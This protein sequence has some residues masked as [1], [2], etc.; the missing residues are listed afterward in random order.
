MRTLIN[1]LLVAILTGL[2][3]QYLGWI[4]VPIIALAVSIG[5]RELRLSPWQVGAGSALA[6]AVMLAASARSAAFPSLLGSMG[7]VFQ[8]PGLALICV[9]LLLPFALGWSTS[10]VATGLVRRYR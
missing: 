4:A 9:T 7:K 2:V 8:V 3:A 10:T 5:P 1:V 6:W